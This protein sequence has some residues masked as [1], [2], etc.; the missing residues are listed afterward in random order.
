MNDDKLSRRTFIRNTSLVAAGAIAG[1][2]A[3]KAHALDK[4]EEMA[5]RRTPSYSPQMEYRRLG[6]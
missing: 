3:G 2:L 4:S 6:T 1:A 5:I